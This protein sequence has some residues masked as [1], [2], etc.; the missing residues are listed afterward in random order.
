MDDSLEQVRKLVASR[1]MIDA[2]KLYRTAT[3][4]GL[5][6]A[7]DAI[8][9]Y[10]AGGPLEVAETSVPRAAAL[11]PS[12]PEDAEI[13]RLLE[14][15]RKFEAV[16]V[17]RARSGL[18]LAAA[19]EAVDNLERDLERKRGTRSSRSGV[20]DRGGSGMRRWI[21]AALVFAAAVAAYLFLR[22]GS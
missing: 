15:G 11:D 1:R 21:A 3:G 18:D 4:L 22:S 8:D 20:V 17:L 16:K 7:K 2:I 12:A 6:E 19:K 10:A 13:M 14:V 5:K 9:R